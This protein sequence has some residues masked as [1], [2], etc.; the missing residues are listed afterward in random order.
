MSFAKSLGAEIEILADEPLIIPTWND[1]FDDPV[2]II[3][4]KVKLLTDP[5]ATEEAEQFAYFHPKEITT[6]DFDS[7]LNIHGG[8]FS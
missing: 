6:E 3:A 5:R 1:K 2:L 8:L 4:Y 7:A